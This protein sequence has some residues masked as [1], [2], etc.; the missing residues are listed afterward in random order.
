MCITHAVLRA[1]DDARGSIGLGR[2]RDRRAVADFRHVAHA[3]RRFAHEAQRLHRVTRANGRAAV[4]RL[5]YIARTT[6]S[7]AHRCS[8]HDAIRRTTV[9]DAV[10]RLGDVTISDRG[11]TH[12]SS[13]PTRTGAWIVAVVRADIAGATRLPFSAQRRACAHVVDARGALAWSADARVRRARR[14]GATGPRICAGC[15]R[16]AHGSAALTVIAD[17]RARQRRIANLACAADTVGAIAVLPAL[18]LFECAPLARQAA[19]VIR[20]Q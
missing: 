16:I 7:T 13:G 10:A 4:T 2:T 1:A 18:R 3:I 17:R 19:R 14:C 6:G 15:G 9:A 5:R 11:A 8:G 20:A 12:R